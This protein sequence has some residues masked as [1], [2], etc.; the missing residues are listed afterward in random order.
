M[1]A[2]ITAAVQCKTPA[3]QD[4]A[5]VKEG[6]DG[7]NHPLSTFG[8]SLMRYDQVP[9]A[10]SLSVQPWPG[11]YWATYRGGVA[12]RWTQYLNFDSGTLGNMS[13][14]DF[15][16]TPMDAT[17]AK[18]LG[19]EQIK[20]LSP[21]E[22]FDLLNDNFSFP[23]T[24][25]ALSDTKAAVG[26]N[27]EVPTWFGICHAW[28]PAASLSPYPG[29]L[30]RVK[31]KAGQCVTFYRDD[32]KALASLSFDAGYGADYNT[33][34][35][36]QRC[37]L[38][39]GQITRD[40]QGR[41]TNAECR[42][43]N[44]GAFHLVMSSFISNNKPVVLDVTYSDEVWNQPVHSYKFAYSNV[45]S[46]NGFD[47]LNHVRAPGTVYLVDVD[48]ELKYIVESNPSISEEQLEAYIKTANYKYSLELDSEYRIIG[49]EWNWASMGAAGI[50]MPDFVWTPSEKNTNN[51]DVSST[52][53]ESLIAGSLSASPDFCQGGDLPTPTPN[54]DQPTP[55]D[56]EPTPTPD[57]PIVNPDQPGNPGQPGGQRPPLPKLKKKKEQ[58]PPNDDPK[59]TKQW[60]Y[61][62]PVRKLE[63]KPYLDPN[64]A[65]VMQS[66]KLECGKTVGC[67]WTSVTKA[68]INMR[69]Q[70]CSD[71]PA[72]DICNV[73]DLCK[74]SGQVCE[75]K[76]IVKKRKNKQL[77]GQSQNQKP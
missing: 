65:C 73:K 44:P 37:N 76:D 71:Y 63:Y 49:G 21:A 61:T 41:I 9:T 4:T 43:T 30:V 70:K 23:L 69:S 19:D 22:K 5:K 10:G 51:G 60:E 29:K 47:S 34:F 13:W 54:P 1:L 32:L 48:Y 56:P 53:I 3:G 17:A 72:E 66:N 16:Y 39:E 45:R 35:L 40:A 24:G 59:Q 68:C 15:A 12:Y 11:Y 46:A 62:V 25:R 38:A 64:D 57:Q 75:A 58:R 8:V 36:G 26:A 77:Q 7:A 55:S 74:W 31:N 67:A 33:M 52:K 6:Y 2:L 18:A 27:G 20:A 28:A 42:D 14:R 50:R